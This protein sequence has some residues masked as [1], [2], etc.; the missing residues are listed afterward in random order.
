MINSKS[1]KR[2]LNFAAVLLIILLVFCCCKSSNDHKEN[3][4]SGN[5]TTE[6]KN[7]ETTEVASV[8]TGVKSNIVIY[9]DDT[10]ETVNKTLLD[11][12]KAEGG[13]TQEV[14][15]K[16]V[17][18]ENGEAVS[19]LKAGEYE[20]IYYCDRSDVATVSSA[21]TVKPKDNT[22]PVIE[23]A[24]DKI[25]TI[26]DTVSYRSG[27]TVSDNDDENVQLTVD[28]SKVD[29]TRLGTYSLTYSATDKRGNTASVTVKITVVEKTG[30]D[31]GNEACSKEELDALC[32]SILK[33]IIKD[34]MTVREKAE[35]IYTKVNSAK[36]VNTS[37]G[38]DNWIEAAYVL[39]TKNRG[40]CENYAAAS[41]ALLSAADIPNYDME[42]YGGTSEHY[43]NIAYVDGGWYHFDACPTLK[44]FYLK[45]FLI[46]DDE[47]KEYSERCTT[48]P[49][50]LTYDPDSCPYEIVKSRN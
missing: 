29:L 16:I 30:D 23:G 7:S 49:N 47:A 32:A 3:N 24:S 45:I 26:G 13:K 25:V 39:L 38:D 21:L 43:W 6:V 41:K 50:Y 35:A 4:T 2:A 12:V 8:I 15:V 9:E 27:I 28:A 10:E 42:R 33:K 48:I 36:Y 22:P 37:E 17:S 31:E 18:K 20:L 11:G 1:R 44:K 40:D 34:D 5:L 19:T 46:T 14:K